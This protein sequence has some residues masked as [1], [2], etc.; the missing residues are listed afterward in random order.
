MIDSTAFDPVSPPEIPPAEPAARDSESGSELRGPASTSPRRDPWAIVWEVLTSRWL[1][2]GCAGFTFLAIGASL[3]IPQLPGQIDGETGAATRWIATAS[4]AYGEFG[5]I[6]ARIGIFSV[7]Q[8]PIFRVV[9]AV[10]GAVVLAQ[11]VATTLVAY[12]LRQLPALL[13][14]AST[15]NGEPLPISLPYRVRRWREVYA[16]EPL[17]TATDMQTLLPVLYDRMERRTVRVAQAPAV[18]AFEQAQGR[19][20]AAAPTDH[21]LLEERLLTVRGRVDVLLRPL[22]PLGMLLAL[23]LIWWQTYWGWEFRPGPI[24]P[25]ER[26]SFAQRGVSLAYTLDQPSPGIMAPAM[27]VEIN[28]R[29]TTIP[30]GATMRATV[31]G[32]DVSAEPGTP[33]LVVQVPDGAALLARPGQTTTSAQIGLG[34]P[35]A[36]SEETLLVPQHGIGL[37]IVRTGGGPLAE[38]ASFLVEIYRGDSEAPVRR[39]TVD[40]SLAEVV[41]AGTSGDESVLLAFVPLSTLDARV[42]HVPAPWLFWLALA[43]T[44]AGLAGYRRRPGFAMVQVGPWPIQRAVVNVQTD[45]APTLAM[46][47]ARF[48]AERGARGAQTETH[49]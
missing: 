18:T 34:F 22:L 42:S 23:L 37:R 4:S 6:M 16:E 21:P 48:E 8:N 30:F 9:L 26:T 5:E 24:I 14:L 19:K 1:L 31:D 47:Q 20:D 13:D 44:L 17:A 3:L 29:T 28:E 25:G 11:L 38:R 12:R 41:E 32:A 10:T 45:D 33:G 36:G 27:R 49:A 35:R 39:F 15:V 7:L 46:V 40:R 2:L 43:L